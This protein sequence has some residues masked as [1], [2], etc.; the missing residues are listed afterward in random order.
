MEKNL[1][2]TVEKNQM[3][4]NITGLSPATFYTFSITPIAANQTL[5][6]PMDKNVTTGKG[7][8]T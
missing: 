1:T 8:G 7:Q 2:F 3:S 4:Y 6:D 5:G